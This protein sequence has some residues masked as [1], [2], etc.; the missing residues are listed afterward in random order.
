MRI[1]NASPLILLF[2]EINEPDVI[3]LLFGI[4]EKLFVPQRVKEEIKSIKAKKNLETLVKNGKIRYCKS[5]KDETLSF[6]KKRF[7][8]LDEGELSVISIAYEYKLDSCFVIIDE[9]VGR[10]VSEKLGL[11]LKGVFGI[12]IELYKS[13]KITKER[14]IQ[15]CRK[16]D[17]SNFRINFKEMGYEWV[18][19]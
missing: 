3:E 6:M 7:P 5:C 4:D 8:M 1:F 15:S 9:S 19:K 12:L 16:I 14:L 2:E 13:K 11:K 10:S 17:K 18:I